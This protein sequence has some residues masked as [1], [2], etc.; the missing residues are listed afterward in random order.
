MAMVK[1][2]RQYERWL[3]GEKL[4]RKQ[5]MVANCYNCNGLD[6]GA[7]DCGGER[8]CPLYSYFF[9]A[10]SRAYKPTKQPLTTL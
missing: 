8:S 9:Y 10:H 6:E 4:T 5:A 7:E 1:G 2:K 3:R